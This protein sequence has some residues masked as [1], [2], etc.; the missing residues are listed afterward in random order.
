MQAYAAVHQRT[1]SVGG[2]A[3]S[4]RAESL[5]RLQRQPGECVEREGPVLEVR[6][7]EA[8][9]VEDHQWSLDLQAIEVPRDCTIFYDGDGRGTATTT[10]TAT[11]TTHRR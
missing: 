3:E 7:Q 5:S 1:E 9:R 6:Q 10:A 2:P 8:A 11:T 4:H